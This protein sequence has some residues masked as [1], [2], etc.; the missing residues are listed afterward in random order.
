MSEIYFPSCNF[1][2]ADK[3]TAQKIRAYLAQKMPVAGCCRVDHTAYR[4]GDHAI[5]LCQACREMMEE[6]MGDRMTHENLICYLLRDEEFVWP[7]H[8]GMT[9]T[10]QDCWRDRGHPEVMDAVWQALHRMNITVLEMEEN[11]ENSVFCGNLHFEPHRAE[12]RALLREYADV[13][14]WQLPPEVEQALMREQVEKFPC[15]TAVCYC[16]RCIRGVKTGG[17]HAVHVLQ[18]AFEEQ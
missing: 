5:Y 10:V 15:E 1:T 13:P 17:G 2:A 16:N 6:T 18:L 7:N 12:N 14:L 11:R 3:V 8:T 4:A 9:V